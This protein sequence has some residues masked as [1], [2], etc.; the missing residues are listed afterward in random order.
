MS[1]EGRPDAGAVIHAARRRREL[2]LRAVADASAKL[3]GRDPRTYSKLTRTTLWE[4]ERLGNSLI[5]SRNIAPGK[6]RAIVAILWDGNY[7]DFYQETG[8]ERTLVVPPSVRDEPVA[9]AA[10]IPYYLEGEALRK[11]RQ[12]RALPHIAM[13]DLL[14]AM[15]SGRMA[16]MLNPEQQVGCRV[17]DGEEE[18]RAGEVVILKDD[19][20][21]LTAAVYTGDGR[22][23]YLS[24]EPGDPS[25]LSADKV[26][27]VAQWVKPELPAMRVSA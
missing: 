27:A 25:E 22:A 1:S 24:P 13:A 7:E 4:I 18:P 5:E 15:R 17:V 3:E 9:A 16:P 8:L 10:Y 23:R 26:Y 12:R 21:R 6:I 20:G 19:G 2:T 11:Q 14:F